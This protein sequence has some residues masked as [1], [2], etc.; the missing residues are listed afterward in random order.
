MPQVGLASGAKNLLPLHPVTMVRPCHDIFP[1]H[2]LKKTRPARAGIKFRL[3]CKQR[4]AATDAIIDPRF[5]LIVKC[6]AKRRLRPFVPRDAI[7]LR[8]QC[9]R[10]FRVGFDNFRSGDQRSWESFVIEKANL[11]H[12]NL[13]AVGVFSR[14]RAGFRLRVATRGPRGQHRREHPFETRH[15][16]AM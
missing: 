3:R 5:M 15:H 14:R 8:R 9:F 6:A 16:P 12:G 7:L 1:G 2:R 11:Y 4:Q 10:P 13:I